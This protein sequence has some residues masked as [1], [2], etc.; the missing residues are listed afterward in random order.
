MVPN[1]LV[2]IGAAFIPF[3]IAFVWFHPKAFGGDTWTKIAGLTEEQGK[4]SVKPLKLALSIFLNFLLA[5]GVFNLA[6]HQFSMVGLV[7]GDVELLKV[8]TGAAFMAEFGGR[9]LSFGHGLTHG[10][11]GFFSY[12]LP[13]LGYAVIF[14]RKSTKYLLVNSGF[15]LIS[16][17]LMGGVVTQWGA[18]AI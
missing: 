6:V 10:F 8:G 16:L 2:L 12:I 1:L 9:H 13:I 15:W 18:V 7:G 5:F 4:T 17:M 3:L 11:I 14:E